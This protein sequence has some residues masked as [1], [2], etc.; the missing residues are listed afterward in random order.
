M[1]SLGTLFWY[2]S[3]GLELDKRMELPIEGLNSSQVEVLEL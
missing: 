3:V 1:G 2:Q